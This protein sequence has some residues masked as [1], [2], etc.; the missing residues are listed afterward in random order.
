M[1]LNQLA[2]LNPEHVMFSLDR[3]VMIPAS[4]VSTATVVAPHRPTIKT[5]TVTDGM[6]LKLKVAS[7]MI[8]T[9]LALQVAL[10]HGLTRNLTHFHLSAESPHQIWWE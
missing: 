5:I 3:V 7:R 9:A 6:D 8:L 4:T 1:F 10:T 2:I